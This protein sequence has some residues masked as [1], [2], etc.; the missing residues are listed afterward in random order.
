MNEKQAKLMR[1]FVKHTRDMKLA[2]LTMAAWPHMNHKAKGKITR[3]MRTVCA[4][5]QA[6]KDER[7]K[8]QEQEKIARAAANLDVL[9]GFV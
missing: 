9:K 8:R 6:I 7:K 2:A 3:W 4:T 5:M 1:Y